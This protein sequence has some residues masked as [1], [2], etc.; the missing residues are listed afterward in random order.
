[1]EKKLNIRLVKQKINNINYDY[2]IIS[3]NIEILMKDH[4]MIDLGERK[5][6]LF[7]WEFTLD[8]IPDILEK[9]TIITVIKAILENLQYMEISYDDLR[10][11]IEL[12][13]TEGNIV[14]SIDRIRLSNDNIIDMLKNIYKNNLNPE[15]FF[16]NSE[17]DDTLFVYGSLLLLSILENSS[18]MFLGHQLNIECILLE[19]GLEEKEAN[20]IIIKKIL[21]SF[22]KNDKKE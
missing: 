21:D 17:I 13:I 7:C 12:N 4:N 14:N 2:N 3:K 15:G 16:K 20:N 19:N 8:V 6:N 22:N 5:I 10:L 1:M 11:K 9:H 18:F